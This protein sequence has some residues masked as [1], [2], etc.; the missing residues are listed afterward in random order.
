MDERRPTPPRN[1]S[2]ALAIAAVAVLVVVAI[3]GIVLA[4]MRGRDTPADAR[5]GTDATQP[6]S[7]AM[8]GAAASLAADAGAGP[9]QIVFAPA[10]DRLSEPASSKLAKFAESMKKDNRLV[11]IATKIEARPDRNEQMEL[12]KKR[13]YAVRQVLEGRG[14]AL[15]TMRIEIT[16]LPKGLVTAREGNLVEVLLR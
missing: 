8:T 4:G 1:P 12:A 5:A 9:N 14:I 3:A 6:A 7:A 2:R 13:A 10:S 15:A 16:E 11:I